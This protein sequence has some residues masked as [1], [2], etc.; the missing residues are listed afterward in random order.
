MGFA[1]GTLTPCLSYRW[2]ER[3]HGR[4]GPRCNAIGDLLA[5]ISGDASHSPPSPL[6]HLRRRHL[7]LSPAEAA[8]HWAGIGG[9]G[10]AWP[11]RKWSE[12]VGCTRVSERPRTARCR[13]SSGINSCVPEP[14]ERMHSLLL[15]LN[16]PRNATAAVRSKRPHLRAACVPH[17]GWTGMVG[18]F[19]HDHTTAATTSRFT[20]FVS[21]SNG[22]FGPLH[23]SR[24]F[25]L[26]ACLTYGGGCT[27]ALHPLAHLPAYLSQLFSLIRS[28]VATLWASGKP[29]RSHLATA[30]GEGP[31]TRRGGVARLLL[32]SLSLSL[33]F[34]CHLALAALLVSKHASTHPRRQPTLHVE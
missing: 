28:G 3:V 23:F 8:R 5:D 17:A 7:A 15:V 4:S 25:S 14:E 1:R 32:H 34:S 19:Y 9:R 16:A 24:S 12:G 18:V 13:L 6:P 2:H 30:L 29:R 10:A 11:C 27:R 22:C 26:C 31:F 21:H 20:P 33:L